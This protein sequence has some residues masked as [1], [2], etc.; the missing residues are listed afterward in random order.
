MVCKLVSA[1]FD[2]SEDTF[3]RVAVAV[4]LVAKLDAFLDDIET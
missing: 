2:L 1:A 4:G 3:D